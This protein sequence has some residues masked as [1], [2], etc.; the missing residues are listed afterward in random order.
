MMGNAIGVGQTYEVKPQWYAIQTRPRHEKRVA[1][2]LR[3][4]AW[5][6]FLPVYRCRHKWKNGVT[7]DLELPLFPCYLFARARLHER[8]RMLQL[9][10]IIGIAASTTHPTAVPD[11]DI[12]ALR[13]VTDT[14]GAQPHP[15]MNVGDR[16]R[17][18]AGPLAGIEGIMT[19]RKQQ[20]RLILT[21]EVVMRSIAVE[22]SQFDVEVIAAP[23]R[24]LT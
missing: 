21:I 5:E 20:C 10:G 8:L 24:W 22:V 19:R 12:E 23:R 11:L 2:Q 9:P 15:F 4:K 17:I 16:V 3:S 18:I 14:Q 6:A 1:E 7:A 13:L